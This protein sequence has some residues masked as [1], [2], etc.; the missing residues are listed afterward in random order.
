MNKIINR[1]LLTGGKFIPEMNL[2]QPG[3]THSAWGSFTKHRE[4]IQKFKDTGNLKY[5][6][7]NE[8]DKA[9]IPHDAAY[10][11]SKDVAK[12]TISEKVLKER[13]CEIARNPNYDGYQ[14]ALAS[15]FYKFFD[16]KK[17]VQE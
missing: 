6:Y 9:C 15:M 12:N 7:R 13:G 17:Q 10:S 4:R 8:L 1:I 3:F 14:K 5:L 2:R 11:V 16:R